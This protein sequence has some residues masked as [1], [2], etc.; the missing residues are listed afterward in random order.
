MFGLY[1]TWIFK[2]KIQYWRR[3]ALLSSRLFLFS[4]R[5]S[6]L[7]S[8]FPL[9]P[10]RDVL[11]IELFLRDLSRGARIMLFMSPHDYRKTIFIL[12]T[13]LNPCFDVG[14]SSGRL[15]PRLSRPLDE[16]TKINIVDDENKI[17]DT[18]P[19]G[20]GLSTPP[21]TSFSES[22][23]VSCVSCGRYTHAHAPCHVGLNGGIC[24]FYKPGVI[25]IPGRDGNTTR[26]SPPLAHVRRTDTGP[27]FI[28]G[29]YRPRRSDV[30]SSGSLRIRAVNS[31]IYYPDAPT[32]RYADEYRHE[33]N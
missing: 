5:F 12:D 32:H 29:A 19:T 13:I 15:W 1:T 16:G 8:P 4:G 14:L 3:G 30:G 7:L 23:R 26:S 21:R 31:P 18:G 2:R 28:A 11:S 17:L 9:V 20:R 22:P 10:T 25:C 27:R 33:F 6:S 24:I